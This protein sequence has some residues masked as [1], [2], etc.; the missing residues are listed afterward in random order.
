[1]PHG[2]HKQV[3]V[4]GGL[5]AKYLEIAHAQCETPE[6]VEQDARKTHRGSDPHTLGVGIH[7][8]AWSILSA[9]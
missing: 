6:D 9:I 2:A 3:L 7:V 5:V 1:M 8:S 4:K